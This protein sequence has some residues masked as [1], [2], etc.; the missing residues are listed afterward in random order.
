MQVI[1]TLDDRELAG[2]NER[3]NLTNSVLPFG[4]QYL[5]VHG[6]KKTA[7]EFKHQESDKYCNQT[8]SQQMHIYSCHIM[9]PTVKVLLNKHKH[10]HAT[11]CAAVTDTL[12]HTE[13]LG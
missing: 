5:K 8:L 10:T 7:A 12:C 4:S 3:I 1:K 2:D 11:C 13:M 9:I 6:L